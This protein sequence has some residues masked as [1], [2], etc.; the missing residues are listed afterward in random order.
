MPTI[1]SISFR[2]YKTTFRHAIWSAITD[3]PEG[4]LDEAAFPAYA[5][6]NP[7]INWLFWQRL[8]V[9]MKYIRKRAPYESVL[10]FGCGSGVLL[11]FLA[12]H[13][14]RVIGVDRDLSPS[15]LIQRYIT[16][17]SWVQIC[18]IEDHPLDEIPAAT[19]DLI[20]ALDVLEHVIDLSTVLD[21]LIRLLKP[22]GELIVSGPT[23]N[24]FYQ[25]GRK[26]AGKTFSGVY[27]ER[28]ISEIAKLVKK[29][30]NVKTLANLYSPITLFS[31]FS[32]TV[33]SPSED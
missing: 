7:L 8:N 33:N 24:L 19:F 11:P 25:V 17:P 18:N 28:G 1:F 3:A 16:F 15:M 6:P 31:I 32:V 26:L 2:D 10:D 29:K 12:E 23:E 14:P 22:N 21:Q 27:H 9:V 13:S 20:T 4:S 30:G 5:H